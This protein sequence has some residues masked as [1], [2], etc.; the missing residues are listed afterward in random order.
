M[1]TLFLRSP[2]VGSI[3]KKIIAINPQL[4]AP[5]IIDLIRQSAKQQVQSELPG[6]FAQAE[7]I[8]EVKALR[9]AQL[10]LTPFQVN[11]A[12]GQDKGDHA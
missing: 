4:T 1:E 12:L 7:V 6:V 3:T 2:S 10:T 9:L 8:D 11:Q 5:Q